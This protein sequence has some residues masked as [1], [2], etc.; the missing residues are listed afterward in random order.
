MDPEVEHDLEQ[1]GLGEG[2]GE[3]GD[4]IKIPVQSTTLHPRRRETATYCRVALAAHVTLCSRVPVFSR[5]YSLHSRARSPSRSRK[6]CRSVD[7]SWGTQAVSAEAIT[8]VGIQCHLRILYF[9]AS[10]F[11]SLT[12]RDMYDQDNR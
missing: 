12:R 4:G 3:M 9:Y 5:D 10:S 8:K 7:G 6:H 1:A 11:P 2:R